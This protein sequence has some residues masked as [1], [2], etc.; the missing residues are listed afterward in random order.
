MCVCVLACVRVCV[1]GACSM[2]AVLVLLC[3]IVY[4]IKGMYECVM[5]LFYI[6]LLHCIIIILCI[7]LCEALR[8]YI[9][10]CFIQIPF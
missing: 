3:I 1:C 8:R 10:I 7:A 9:W 5:C 2:R 4:Y 6:A